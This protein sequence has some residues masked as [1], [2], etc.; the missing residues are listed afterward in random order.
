MTTTDKLAFAAIGISVFTFIFSWY[1]FSKTDELAKNAFNRNYR[2]YV[3]ASN[4]SYLNKENILV[5]AMNVVM[6]RILN[7]PAFITSKKLIFYIREKNTDT[8]LFEHPDYKDELLYP[9]DN[10]QNTIGTDTNIISHSMAEKLSPR[11]LIRKIRIEYQW[12]SDSTLKYYFESVWKYDPK[13]HDWDIIS[14]TGN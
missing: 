6:I 3:T 14:Q 12:I 4:F 7:A 10:T 1:S 13:K 9:L 2:P 11:E 5:P 8:I